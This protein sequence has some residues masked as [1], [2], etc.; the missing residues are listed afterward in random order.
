MLLVLLPV[1]L[2]GLGITLIV[3]DMIYDILVFLGR[4]AYVLL[5]LVF[6]IAAILTR[7]RIL[8]YVLA[9]VSMVLT[10]LQFVLG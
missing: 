7:K 10:T 4:Y 9:F 5:A 3:K 1:W 6:A 8:Q 2:I